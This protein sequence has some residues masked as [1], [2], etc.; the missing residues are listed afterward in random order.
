MEL[1]IAISKKG[2]FKKKKR[3][4]KA[5]AVQIGILILSKFTA[6]NFWIFKHWPLDGCMNY[7]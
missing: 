7:H 2:I 5:A 3:R 1:T 4:T 6:N